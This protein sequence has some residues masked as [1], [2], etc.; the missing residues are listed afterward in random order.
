[1]T[2]HMVASD[3]NECLWSSQP[4]LQNS[5]RRTFQN[6]GSYISDPLGN[7]FFISFILIPAA[8]AYFL[9][10]IQA[11]VTHTSCSLSFRAPHVHRLL[12]AGVPRCFWG[13]GHQ[14]MIGSHSH[15]SIQIKYLEISEERYLS[16]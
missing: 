16:F 5:S 9:L 7:R 11:G 6:L 13:E 12:G 15:I 4:S 1:M 10:E 8:G 14:V 3:D 2:G